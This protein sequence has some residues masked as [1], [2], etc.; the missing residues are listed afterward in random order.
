MVCPLTLLFFK[1]FTVSKSCHLFFARYQ[2]KNYSQ[3]CQVCSTFGFTFVVRG[4]HQMLITDHSVCI[5][6]NAFYWRLCRLLATVD[7]GAQK[8]RRNVDMH[9][10]TAQS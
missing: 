3:L 8:H 1:C 5:Y 9:R 7:G 6:R 4:T 2:E 10:M